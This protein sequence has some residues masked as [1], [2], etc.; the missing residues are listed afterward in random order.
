MFL[1]ATVKFYNE[2][3]TKAKLAIATGA[4]VCGATCFAVWK[5][6]KKKD[7]SGDEKIQNCA[8]FTEEIR[9]VQVKSFEHEKSSTATERD[10]ETPSTNS[11]SFRQS[12][13]LPYQEH[14]A[15][16]VSESLLPPEL[17]TQTCAIKGSL[18][19]EKHLKLKSDQKKK[20]KHDIQVNVE[21]VST[22]LQL[23]S[24]VHYLWA[25]YLFFG[26]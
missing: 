23:C 12:I 2:L 13:D 22:L 11:I 17:P 20:T 26:K 15:I 24:I 6:A 9:S 16:A 19:E 4:L 14:S 3:S 5:Y 1:Q 21:N 18:T 7:D 10:G 25:L 8:G